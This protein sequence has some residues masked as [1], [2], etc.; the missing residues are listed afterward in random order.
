MERKRD[1]GIALMLLLLIGGALIGYFVLNGDV[2]KLQDLQT[3]KDININRN[4]KLEYYVGYW[5]ETKEKA[6][7]NSLII[8]ELDGSTFKMD[9]NFF[10]IK[11]FN[12]LSCTIDKD[13]CNISYEQDTNSLKAKITLFDNQ[14]LLL[15]TESTYENIDLD[16]L[17]KYN[18][19][20]KEE[21]IPSAE[22]IE[23]YTG[24]T[25]D[26]K[27]VGTWYLSYLSD[28]SKDKFIISGYDGTDVNMYLTLKGI[29]FKGAT[30][31]FEGGKGTV[32]FISRETEK[33]VKAEVTLN[34]TISIDI[35]E[36]EI[37]E[38]STGVYDF[39]VKPKVVSYDDYIARWYIDEN[40]DDD[41]YLE[42]KY[43]EKGNLLFDL[44][45]RKRAQLMNVAVNIT[46]NI[47][48]FEC[49]GS[50]DETRYLKGYIT[51]DDDRIYIYFYDSTVESIKNGSTFE[52]V[53]KGV[54][55]S[56]GN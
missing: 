45:I 46:K 21:Y 8:T 30:E 16:A 36:S 18:Y 6:G 26:S 9:L 2:D 1:I 50:G 38:I 22:A 54:E 11:E 28:Y 40:K 5:Y 25:I 19:Y 24:E 44:K 37:E 4:E 39:Q 15:I 3:Q 41:N 33:K 29:A 34:E 20:L 47:G 53:Y 17:Y 56:G 27:Y 49:K 14:I 32:E 31:T 13:E 55:D 7:L 10:G 23:K 48:T 43:D 52:Y 51:F 12:N 35:K 42:I